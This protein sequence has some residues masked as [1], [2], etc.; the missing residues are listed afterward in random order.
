MT[1]LHCTRCN[2]H[3]THYMNVAHLN[4][5]V[6]WITSSASNGLIISTTMHN[7]CMHNVTH[8]LGRRRTELFALALALGLGL[9]RSTWLAPHQVYS[10]HVARVT[11][12][13]ADSCSAISRS[14]HNLKLHKF[15]RDTEEC[16]NSVHL[17]KKPT[18]RNDRAGFRSWCLINCLLMR[19]ITSSDS[20]G[21]KNFRFTAHNGG[22]GHIRMSSTHAY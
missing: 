13:I 7:V 21:N 2:A 18:W 17:K 5:Q 3:D 20:A 19:S 12:R 4:A 16:S 8:A 11:W 6:A 14:L 1:L 9:L 10:K 22:G 15:Q